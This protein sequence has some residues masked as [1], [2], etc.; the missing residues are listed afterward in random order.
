MPVVQSR[1][2]NDFSFLREFDGIAHE[3]IQDL[4]QSEPI[5]DNE[6]R[7]GRVNTVQKI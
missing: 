3:V 6:S 5:S 2:D 7:D 4:A 1:R